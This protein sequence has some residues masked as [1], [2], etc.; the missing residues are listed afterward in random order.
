MTK[1]IINPIRCLLSN[2]A[3][4]SLTVIGLSVILVLAPLAVD[5]SSTSQAQ[6]GTWWDKA[7]QGG[8]NQVGQAYGGAA[9]P[10]SITVIVID[11][12]RIVLGF[13]GIIAMIIV[14]YAGFKWM[15]SGGSEE[16]VGEAKKM[17]I[18]GIIGLVLILSAYIIANFVINQIHS[19]T[20]GDQILFP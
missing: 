8:L 13:L 1:R 9:E 17:L 2:G 6:A 3:K 7:Q 14:L 10:R 11:A 18:A 4:Y 15:L 12:I 16:K 20:T 5:F 19:A